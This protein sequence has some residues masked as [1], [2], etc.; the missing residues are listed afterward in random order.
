M[1]EVGAR[2]LNDFVE[3]VARLYAIALGLLEFYS[4]TDPSET[5]LRDELEKPKKARARIE[6]A[7]IWLRKASNALAR[8]KM[9]EEGT[10]IRLT[11]DRPTL[12]QELKNGLHL[13]FPVELTS[14]MKRAQLRGIS[15]TAEG[16]DAWI[17]LEVTCPQQKLESAGIT[18]SRLR[19]SAQDDKWSFCLTAGTLC[20]T[21]QER[22]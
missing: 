6:S 11:I 10:I 20:P 13:D 9:D 16:G 18:Q 14:K 5:D 15:A 7:V 2:A 4:I 1:Q 3:V 22:Q 12:L 21:N 17:D 19:K 8:A